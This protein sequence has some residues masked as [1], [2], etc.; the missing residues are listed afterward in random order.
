V[1]WPGR[2]APGQLPGRCLLERAGL[3]DLPPSLPWPPVKAQRVTC[4]LQGAG[5][6]PGRPP[7]LP[8]ELAARC[9][10]LA[11]QSGVC[12]VDDLAAGLIGHPH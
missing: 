11:S 8:S 10:G 1:G 2:W 9:C 7:L 6:A 4:S 5:T 12:R 3:V